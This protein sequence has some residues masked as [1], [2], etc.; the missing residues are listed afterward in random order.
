MI[1]W[2]IATETTN[3]WHSP[4]HDDNIETL[5]C[6]KC[7]SRPSV[8]PI[9]QPHTCVKCWTILHCCPE[10]FDWISVSMDKHLNYECRGSIPQFDSKCL[11]YHPEGYGHHSHREFPLIKPLHCENC[12]ITQCANCGDCVERD[13]SLIYRLTK[14]SVRMCD[15]C[16]HELIVET[17]LPYLP[18]VIG[19]VI[20]SMVY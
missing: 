15:E 14:F 5:T 13:F 16:S 3:D 4:T 12:W 8:Y 6:S 19:S 17:L 10:C 7:A 11:R 1:C 2:V 18:C 9:S 20:Y